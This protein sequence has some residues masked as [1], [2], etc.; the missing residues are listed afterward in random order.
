MTHDDELAR[1]DQAGHAHLR[2]GHP[3]PLPR[4]RQTVVDPVHGPE[5]LHE[6]EEQI[7]KGQIRVVRSSAAAMPRVPTA[8]HRWA[9]GRTGAAAACSDESQRGTVGM[10]HV[11]TIRTLSREPRQPSE[12]HLHTSIPTAYTPALMC[13]RS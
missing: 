9:Q 8:R 1:L 11:S 2:P 13:T 4:S 10:K 7:M 6:L 3:G 12:S 5:H